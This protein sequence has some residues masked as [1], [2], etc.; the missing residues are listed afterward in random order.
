MNGWWLILVLSAAE[1]APRSSIAFQ[2]YVRRVRTESVELLGGTG[3][4]VWVDRLDRSRAKVVVR[5]I[6]TGLT[7]VPGALIHDW[8]GAVFVPGVSAAFVRDLLERYDDYQVF[9]APA[10]ARSRLLGGDGD[11]RRFWMRWEKRMRLA[12]HALEAEYEATHHQV[13]ERCW[14]SESRAVRVREVEGWGGGHERLREPG[15]GTGYIWRVHSFVR[16]TE[17]DGGVTLEMRSLVLSR[18]I[19]A[20][21]AWLVHPL[22]RRLSRGAMVTTLEQAR[23]ALALGEN[24]HCWVAGDMQHRRLP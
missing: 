4:L 21:F 6:G 7:S 15:T 12:S 18:D 13:S 19:P 3:E 5:P 8:T 9:F 20:A 16:A 11:M 23:A 2:E 24:P 17:R 10:V 14:W 1:L 22:V